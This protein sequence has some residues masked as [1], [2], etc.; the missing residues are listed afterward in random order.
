MEFVVRYVPESIRW[1]VTKRKFAEVR[2]L[3][4]RAAKMNG[5]SV[6]GRFLTRIDQDEHS[7]IYGEVS[8]TSSAP[9]RSTDHT[10]PSP[11]LGPN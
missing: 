2:Q 5:K 6:P 3:V 11:V 7:A 1:L 10:R 4:L 8:A 9:R